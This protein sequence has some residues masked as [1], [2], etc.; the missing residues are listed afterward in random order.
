MLLRRS[1]GW[2]LVSVEHV[3]A[4]PGEQARI[5]D[6]PACQ[7]V[8]HALQ[9]CMIET[10]QGS[11]LRS[12]TQSVASALRARFDPGPGMLAGLKLQAEYG[13]LPLDD[14]DGLGTF[15][16]DRLRSEPTLSQLVFADAATGSTSGTRR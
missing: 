14:L 15:F 11:M 3:V 2:S 1:P 8:R 6:P 10:L 12:A 5:E 16:A 9:P 13:R 4:V 7:A